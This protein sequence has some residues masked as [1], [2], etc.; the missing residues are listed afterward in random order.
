MNN[1]Y[2]V[3]ER[4]YKNIEI[5]P[6]IEMYRA[7]YSSAPFE[8][9]SKYADYTE[10]IFIYREEDAAKK[11]YSTAKSCVEFAYSMEESD[12]GLSD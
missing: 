10:Y 7:K 11:H 2:C 12:N 6:K 3:R 1:F 8:V 4:Y 9:C 5:P